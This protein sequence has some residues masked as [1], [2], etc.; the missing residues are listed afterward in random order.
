MSIVDAL[1]LALLF[2]AGVAAA[3][4]VVAGW[5]GLWDR[6]AAGLTNDWLGAGLV[7]TVAFAASVAVAVRI[8][9]QVAF[10]PLLYLAAACLMVGAGLVIWATA[11]LRGYRQ[12]R[13]AAGPDAVN[14]A[15]GR[16][17]ISG[18]VEAHET[19]ESPFSG[20]TAVSFDARITEA[21]PEAR[22]G[23]D[24]VHEEAVRL[25]FSLVD[26]TGSV[27][28]DPEAADLRMGHDVWAHV[29]PDE[30]IPPEIETYLAERGLHRVGQ[31]DGSLAHRLAGPSKGRTYAEKH[32][33][34]GDEAVVLGEAERVEGRLVVAGGDPFVLKE[35][36]LEATLSNYRTVVA[37]GGPVGAACLLV[38][39]VLLGL[40]L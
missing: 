13:T 39:T 37:R 40:V 34:P 14:A 17:A 19:V 6:R 2:I 15:P 3:L 12:L 21:S 18:T 25:P 35:G 8:P 22:R 7:G 4:V 5:L 9:A 29:G 28:V 38:G 10:G 36:S 32:L 20:A 23:T 24:L 26:S 1:L 16:V 27:R 11:N 30:E 33:A 31:S